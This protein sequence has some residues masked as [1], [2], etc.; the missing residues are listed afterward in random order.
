MVW[1]DIGQIVMK[2]ALK[3]YNCTVFAYGQS[4]C[5]KSYSV[6][7]DSPNWGIIPRTVKALFDVVD[8][9]KD[10]DVRF[11][12]EIAMVEVYMDEVYDLL[13]PRKKDRQKLNV[14]NNKGE[15]FIY[16]PKDRKNMDKIWRACSNH[17]K[18]ESFRKM[19]D[20]NRSIRAT[21][22][23]P[24]SSRGHTLFILRFRKE[25]TLDIAWKRGG[26]VEEF[27]SK[28]CLVDLAGSERA[29]DTGLTGVGLEEGIAINQSLSALGCYGLVRWQCLVQLCK[30]ERVNYSDKLT[31]LLAESLGGNAVTVM[32]AALSPADINYN[33]TLSTLRFADNA[34]KMPV[35]VKKQLDP[36]AE[37]IRQLQE[38]NAKLQAQL[39]SMGSEE[40]RRQRWHSLDHQ[41]FPLD[42]QPG[43]LTAPEVSESQKALEDMKAN[44]ESSSRVHLT[45]AKTGVEQEELTV[46]DLETKVKELEDMK[47]NS[48]AKLED[49]E[50]MSEKAVEVGMGKI[51]NAAILALQRQDE[52]SK[53]QYLQDQLSILQAS[54]DQDHAEVKRLEEES[55]KALEEADKAAQAAREAAEHALQ[56]GGREKMEQ[57]QAIA[58]ERDE[59]RTE[60]SRLREEGGTYKQDLQEKQEAIAAI[61]RSEMQSWEDKDDLKARLNKLQGDTTGRAVAP[62]AEFRHT[63]MESAHQHIL[64]LETKVRAMEELDP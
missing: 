18:A 29:H 33:D 10:E 41:I 61:I 43:R 8:G 48:D 12:V 25:V 32:I 45:R 17:D 52:D 4:G 58:A 7:G 16:D 28:L 20:A 3:G 5:G 57:V 38:E 22:M 37:L 63:D 47:N 56:D 2:N 54:A 23:N 26:W 30:G 55:A 35:K 31:K 62:D 27:R 39:Q 42:L 6:V 59:A 21:G 34:K 36:T 9:N 19:G 44:A 53:V 50:K 40:I 14:F 11:H 49:C 46:E 1:Q 13:E 60:A 64:Y 51:F 15:V 24:E